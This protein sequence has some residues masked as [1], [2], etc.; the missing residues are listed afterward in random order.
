MKRLIHVFIFLNICCTILAETFEHDFSNKT[1]RIDYLFSGNS[2]NQYVS[3]K[4]Y[5]N[6]RNGQDAATIL[7][8]C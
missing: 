2:K 5:L 4:I 3:V 1:L 7:T 6:Y 8:R